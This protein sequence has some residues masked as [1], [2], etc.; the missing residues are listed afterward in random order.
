RVETL[1]GRQGFGP[2]VR[3]HFAGNGPAQPGVLVLAHLDTVHPVGT[4]E[5]L[6]WHQEDGRCYGPGI[7]DMKGGA[8]LALEAMRQLARAGIEPPL[9]VTF[10]LTS[11]EEVG[12]PANRDLIEA[13]ARRSKYV[14]IPEPGGTA[15]VV[16]GRY[17]IARFFVE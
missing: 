1:A 12:T 4:L 16:S 15:S 11:D 2:C 14:L 3:A 7:Y 17:A 10:L 8:F 9:P 5:T 6:R 13:E